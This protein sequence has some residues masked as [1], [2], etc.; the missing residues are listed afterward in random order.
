MVTC[1][2][3]GRS[4]VSSITAQATKGRHVCET[5]SISSNQSKLSSSD[6]EY[7]PI[8]GGLQAAAQNVGHSIMISCDI[9]TVL[10]CVIEGKSFVIMFCDGSPEQTGRAHAS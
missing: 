3:A 9:K 4:R 2:V 1:H 5:V 6:C 7:W 8:L 10:A